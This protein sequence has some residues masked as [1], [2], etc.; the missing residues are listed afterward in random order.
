MA[1]CTRGD[2][3]DLASRGLTSGSSPPVSASVAARALADQRTGGAQAHVHRKLGDA[4]AGALKPRIGR[5]P[6]RQERAMAISR[7]RA[8]AREAEEDLGANRLEG[9]AV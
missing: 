4:F 1:C 6:C 9:E 2:Q 3:G 5:R 7:A 8:L